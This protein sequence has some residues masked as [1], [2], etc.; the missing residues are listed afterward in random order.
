MKKTLSMAMLL[1]GVSA[2]GASV[3][4]GKPGLALIPGGKAY[5]CIRGGPRDPRG[6]E[7][8]P[9]DLAR[10]GNRPPRRQ[11]ENRGYSRIEEIVPPLDAHGCYILEPGKAYGPAK[12][13]WHYEEPIRT[14][15]F[16]SEV[17]GAQRLPN[18]NTLICAGTIGNLFEVNPA[19]EL[20]WQYV[21]P[22]GRRGRILAQGEVPTSGAEKHDPENSLFKVHRYEPDYPA[23]KGRELTPQG[24]IEL[25]AAQKGRTG[26][27]RTDAQSAPAG[28]P[29][30]RP[31][32]MGVRLPHRRH[33]G[34]FRPVARDRL[35]EKGRRRLCP[36]LVAQAC[37]HRTPRWRSILPL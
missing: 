32:R 20:V 4:E 33:S 26:L 31:L 21:N 12:P 14:D 18:G 17:S 2:V 36:L 27:N 9:D 34:E 1:L 19:G 16:S 13:V 24:V 7:R 11:G 10:S 25:P 35:A 22:V 3:H 15:F 6:S 23:F 30:L 29:K 5:H 8:R 37:H 28:R